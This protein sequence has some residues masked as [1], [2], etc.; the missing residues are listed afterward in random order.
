MADH[1]SGWW[2]WTSLKLKGKV[3]R[4]FTSPENPVNIV[5]HLAVLHLADDPSLVH[6]CFGR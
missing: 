3:P 4:L 6:L 1:P 5:L 2:T